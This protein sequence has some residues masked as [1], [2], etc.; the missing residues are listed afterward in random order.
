MVKIANTCFTNVTDDITQSESIDCLY[1]N[2]TCERSS[3]SVALK[4]ILK[5][6][7]S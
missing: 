3:I 1:L 7:I 6:T 5:F 2:A 4:T